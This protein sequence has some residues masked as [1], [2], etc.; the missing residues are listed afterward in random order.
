MHSQKLIGSSVQILNAYVENLHDQLYSRA[1][2][3]PTIQN[4]TLPYVMGHSKLAYS[5][6]LLGALIRAVC[7]HVTRTGS[8]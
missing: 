4:Y 8:F 6:W 1:Y 3:D 2:R 7:S 5:N